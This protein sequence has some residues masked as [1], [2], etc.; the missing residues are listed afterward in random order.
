MINMTWASQEL[1]DC[2]DMECRLIP[3]IRREEIHAIGMSHIDRAACS[4]GEAV[5]YELCQKHNVKLMAQIAPSGGRN[6][7]N[8][9]T[10]G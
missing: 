4:A 6:T 9:F 3:W 5:Y 1:L 2:P 10:R 8:H 7:Q